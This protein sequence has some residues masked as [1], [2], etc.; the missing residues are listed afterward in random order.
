M[1]SVFPNGAREGQGFITAGMGH[2]ITKKA[3][4]ETTPNSPFLWVDEP[5][6]RFPLIHRDKPPN[7]QLIFSVLYGI[8]Q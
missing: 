5:V 6:I 3:A 1:G 2:Y 8:F 4:R 7:Q